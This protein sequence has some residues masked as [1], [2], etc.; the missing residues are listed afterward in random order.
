MLKK[1]LLFSTTIIATI[2]FLIWRVQ[3][4]GCCIEPFNGFFYPNANK[5][6][7]IFDLALFLLAIVVFVI[8][9][10][11]K[12]CLKSALEASKPIAILSV[13]YSAVAVFQGVALFLSKDKTADKIYA[14]ALFALGLFML[15]YAYSLFFSKQIKKTVYLIP[16]LVFVFRLGCVFIDSFGVVKSSEI[17]LNI[18]ALI[19]CVLFFECFARFNANMKFNFIK[20]LFLTLGV[21]SPVVIFTATLGGVLAPMFFENV[22]RTIPDDNIFLIASAVYIYLYTLICFSKKSICKDWFF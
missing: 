3:L 7:Y 2:G 8:L 9:L 19:V 18:F 1:I 4:I 12:A 11:D 15:Y 21:V 17:V 22:Q 20:K 14:M 10:F 5:F 6:R 16:L 13:L